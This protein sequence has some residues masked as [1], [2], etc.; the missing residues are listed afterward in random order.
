MKVVA[1]FLMF[2]ALA[3]PALAGDDRGLSFSSA[4]ET[5]AEG[6]WFLAAP[7][8][9]GAEAPSAPFGF[10]LEPQAAPTPAQEPPLSTLASH[11]VLR[12][13]DSPRPW[14]PASSLQT[15]SPS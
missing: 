12:L 1:N 11:A 13:E 8:A 14:R 7:C 10:T 5:G 3:G 15:S 4:P 9:A 6:S 2:M